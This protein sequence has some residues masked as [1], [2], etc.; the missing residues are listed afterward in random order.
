MGQ[1]A[2]EVGGLGRKSGGRAVSV[3]RKQSEAAIAVGEGWQSE[4]GGGA[5]VFTTVPLQ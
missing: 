4:T 2:V 5:C 1:P 3:P